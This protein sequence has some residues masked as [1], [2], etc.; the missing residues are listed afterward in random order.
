MD[1]E[2]LWG[3][4]MKVEEC[5]KAGANVAAYLGED[6]EH[7][8]VGSE[9]IATAAMTT[10]LKDV[11]GQLEHFELLCANMRQTEEAGRAA[12]EKEA[13]NLRAHSER[14]DRELEA[15]RKEVP[16]LERRLAEGREAVV[17]AER[18]RRTA[19][20][21]LAAAIAA[22]E[23]AESAREAADK[24]VA[25]SAFEIQA[26]AGQLVEEQSAKG[27][28]STQ[29]QN[30]SETMAALSSEGGREPRGG[31][32]G[33]VGRVGGSHR[34]TG[35]GERAAEM[36]LGRGAQGL[37]GGK[38]GDPVGARGG[39]VRRAPGRGEAPGEGYDRAERRVRTAQRGARRA[40]TRVE[41]AP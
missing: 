27:E 31:C 25:T 1:W 10:H 35:E 30:T 28:L 41:R 26:L 3:K 7:P 34:G 33:R 40:G 6:M 12:A 15:A 24:R 17:V 23:S 29:L 21:A 5:G 4:V 8:A 18:Q 13:A 38:G 9:G 36:G 16:E 22:R 11:L 19:E 14:Q 32:R 20:V 37:G 39:D 2:A